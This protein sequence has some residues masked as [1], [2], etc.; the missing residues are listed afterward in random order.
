MEVERIDLRGTNAYLVDGEVPTLV[1]AGWLWSAPSV[2]ASVEDAGWALG[3]IGR[4]LVTH[5]DAD[6]VGGLSRL[7]DAGLDATVYAAEPDASFLIG[8]AKPP[9][10]NTKGSFQRAVC[11]TV[12]PPELPVERVEEGDA[13]GGF[14]VVETPG[15]TPGHVSY[16]GEGAALVGDAARENGGA[17]EPMPSYMSYDGEEGRGSFRRLLDRLGDTTAYVGHGEPV[18]LCAEE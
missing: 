10:W 8:D 7:A 1:D 11:V 2:R 6:H 4:V 9:L 15:H 16:V 18:E 12:R 5:Y 13:A 14:E 17:L 3:D